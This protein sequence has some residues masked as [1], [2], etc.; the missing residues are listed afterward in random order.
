VWE[1][2][3]T[4]HMEKSSVHDWPRQI[5]PMTT[6][7]IEVDVQS[8]EFDTIT[9]NLGASL[10]LEEKCVSAFNFHYVRKTSNG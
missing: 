3:A 2:I 4:I 8:L 6:I 7:V 10:V 9:R 1:E 5:K